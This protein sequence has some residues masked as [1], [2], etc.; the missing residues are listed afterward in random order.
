MSKSTQ[1][2]N[3]TMDTRDKKATLYKLWIIMS[4]IYSGIYMVHSPK[5]EMGKFFLSN[6]LD[7]NCQVPSDIPS[8]SKN[9][10]RVVH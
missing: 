3:Q 4:G 9:S 6:I 10:I 8:D 7:E 5:V 1:I 2:S